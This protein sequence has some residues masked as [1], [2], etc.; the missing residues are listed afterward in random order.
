MDTDNSKSEKEGHPRG[1]SDLKRLL[2]CPFCGKNDLKFTVMYRA[3]AVCCN[4]CGASTKRFDDNEPHNLSIDGEGWMLL[5]EDQQRRYRKK[6]RK[7][8]EENK[9]KAL[10]AWN[11]RAG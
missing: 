9:A 11:K 6:E 4:N 10:T 5:S 3:R 7:L 2:P 1:V 8:I